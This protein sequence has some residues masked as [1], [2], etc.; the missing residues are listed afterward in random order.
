MNVAGNMRVAYLLRIHL[1]KPILL[2][3]CFTYVIVHSVNGFLSICVL[4]NLPVHV[5][6]VIR[7]HFDSRTNE[8]VRFSRAAALFTVKD[9]SFCRARVTLFDKHFFYYI[10]Y[11]LDINDCI[12][13]LLFGDFTYLIAELFGHFEIISANGVRR[14]EDRPCYFF[15]FE[16]NDFSVSLFY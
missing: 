5:A 7:E 1:V 14:L 16:R 12:A 9:K 2:C 11:L 8:R 15:W 3:K 4:F 13:I 10:L 6:E